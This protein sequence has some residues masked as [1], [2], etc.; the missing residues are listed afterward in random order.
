MRDEH[1]KVVDVAAPSTPVRVLGFKVA[2]AVGD[3]VMVGWEAEAVKRST[4]GADRSKELLDSFSRVRRAEV[5]KREYM[6]PVIIRA[7]ML[8]SLEAILS[9]IQ[10]IEHPEVGI[11][12][13]H[14]GLGSITDAD[15]ARAVDTGA[16]LVGFNVNALPTAAN[17]AH[18]KQVKLRTYHVI[19]ELLEDL[20]QDLEEKLAP[21]IRKTLLGKAMVVKVFSRSGRFV[22]VG[23][24]VMEGRLTADD[25]VDLLRGETRVGRVNIAELRSGREAIKEVGSGQEC[26]VRINTREEVKQ[27]DVLVP[28]EEE[29]ITRTLEDKR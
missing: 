8:G 6:V 10:K 19:Y 13:V 20:R 29:R 3:I 23:A 18:E 21:E 24:R 16:Q 15:V 4:T 12:V 22:T 7:D 11:D 17:A 27:G 1:G 9:E 2:P 26:G 5:I 25:P 14:R 28:Y